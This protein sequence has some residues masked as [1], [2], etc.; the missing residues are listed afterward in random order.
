M[1]VYKHAFFSDPP[2]ARNAAPFELRRTHILLYRFFR[3]TSNTPPPPR[4]PFLPASPHTV[5]E[6]ER[7][8]LHFARCVCAELTTPAGGK[9]FFSYISNLAIP[10]R[11]PRHARPSRVGT[12]KTMT[13]RWAEAQGSNR[14]LLGASHLH[15]ANCSSRIRRALSDSPRPKVWSRLLDGKQA[16][17]LPP[18]HKVTKSERAEPASA[19]VCVC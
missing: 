12:S 4:D 1:D 17:K 3:Q 5:L 7:E 8:T 13:R 11:C 14:S 2:K 15:R 19:G 6:G 18:Q 9:G 16:S 10:L